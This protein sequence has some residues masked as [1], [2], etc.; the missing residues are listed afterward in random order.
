MLDVPLFYGCSFVI[1]KNT[2]SILSLILYIVYCINIIRMV[3]CTV[4][5]TRVINIKRVQTFIKTN[6]NFN[7]S[8]AILAKRIVVTFL[9][10][11]SIG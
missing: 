4:F 11:K 5:L 6:L 10:Y 1:F 3:K 8:V 9:V 2:P 7:Y